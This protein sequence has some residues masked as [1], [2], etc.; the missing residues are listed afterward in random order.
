[1]IWLIICVCVCVCGIFITSFLNSKSSSL[2]R[3][4]SLVF[5]QGISLALLIGNGH[6]ASLF[7]IFFSYF[8]NLGVIVM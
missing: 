2:E 4:V 1:M 3:C 6:S 7:Y 8:V 5:F